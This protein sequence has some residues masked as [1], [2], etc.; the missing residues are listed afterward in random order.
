M[1]KKNNY[2]NKKNLKKRTKI[3]N[4]FGKIKRYSRINTRKDNSSTC[5]MGFIFLVCFIYNYKKL[6]TQ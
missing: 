6:K 2:K 5:Y 3:E 1:K 4:V